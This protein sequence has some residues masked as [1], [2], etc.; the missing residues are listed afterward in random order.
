MIGQHAR[1]DVGDQAGRRGRAMLIGDHAQGLALPGP[2]QHGQQEVAAARPIYPGSAQQQVAH[3]AVAD[4]LLAG[5]LGGAVHAQWRGGVV[6]AIGPRR[7]A[8]E[9]IVGGVMDQGDAGLG[10]G[11]GQHARRLRIDAERRV[12]LAFGAIHRG[13][14]GGVDDDVGRDAFH[15]RG[16]AVRRVEVGALATLAVLQLAAARGRHDPCARRQAAAQFVPDLAVGAEQQD[17]HGV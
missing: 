11:L 13:V 6:F 14:G 10:A 3:A 5:Q 16:Q 17:L 4:G 7:L 9:H 1:G 12:G 8:I 15:Q 2:L